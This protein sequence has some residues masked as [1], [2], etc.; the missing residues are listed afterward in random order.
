MPRYQVTEKR[1]YEATYIIDAETEERAEHLDGAI[2]SE[3]DDSAGGSEGYEMLSCE[4]VA[5]DFEG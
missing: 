3:W 4:Q 1:M 5:D 2:I